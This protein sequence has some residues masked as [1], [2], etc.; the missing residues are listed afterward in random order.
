MTHSPQENRQGQHP[1]RA[2]SNK[3]EDRYGF[4]HIATELARAIQGIGREGSAVIGIEGAWGT[5][6]TSLLNL[7]RTAL[8][9]QQE[10]QTFVLTVS[11]WLDG[12]DTPLVASLL[13]PV[14]A[15][16]AEEE[17][18]RLS[19]GERAELKEK[20][21]LTR[22]ARTLMDYTRATA[23]NLAPVAKI[24]ALIPGAP[25]VSNALNAVAESSWLKEKEKTTADMRTEI[26]QKIE[27][28]DLSFIVLLD[29]LDRLEPAQA[30]EVIRLV[31]SVA[32][33]PRFRYLLCYDKA[34]LSQAISQG[35][36]VA[37]GSLYLQKIIQIAFA[38]PRLESF[39]LRQQF[40][41]AAIELYQTVND[42]PPE[43]GI[44]ADLTAVANIYGATLKTPREVQ[45]VLNALRFR[46]AGMRDYVYFPDLCFL[47]LLRTTNPGLYDWV[48]EYLSEW[49]VVQA[50]DGQV[51][52]EEQKALV[53]SLEHH[54]KRY[55]PA[56][57]H[58]AYMLG[59]WVPGIFG[60]LTEYP[61]KLFAR[62]GPQESAMQTAGKRLSSQVY[63]RY[64]FAFSAP[65]NVLSPQI[66]DQLFT[67]ASQPQK[68][69]EL[70]ECLLGYIQS[71]NL[72]SRTWFEHILTQL[73]SPL[74]EARTSAE[75]RGLLQFFCNN[76]DIMVERYRQDNEWFAL[77]DL[78]TYSVADRLIQ[79]MLRE[80]VASTMKFL[81]AQLQSGKA[82]YWCAEYVRHLLWQHGIV[83]DRTGHQLEE[84]MERS[85]VVILQ[86]TMGKRLKS[87][88]ITDQLPAF[89]LLNWYIWAWRD[90]S[91]APV[92][93]KWVKS[94]VKEDDAFLNLLLLLRYYGTSSAQ[95]YYQA[96]PL[97]DMTEFL[98]DIKTVTNRIES[99]KQAGRFPERVKQV[100][101]S[102]RRSR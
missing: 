73:T 84:W 69:Q 27:E 26:A 20:K 38:L 60:G 63:W 33:F 47:Q 53:G 34:V 64:Y 50:E 2:I 100:E 76:G 5:G 25:D 7:L 81:I 1:D 46:Y 99:I 3:E 48:E 89:A 101:Q 58:S 24:A 97:A 70:A 11:P 82:W 43:K 44:L 39:A 41:D 56:A 91:G 35:L 9:E 23:R 13:L 10:R 95:G 28:L 77:Q 4:T 45:T 75:C 36:G 86:Q 49:N 29:D 74:I 78:D 92:V 16:I 55:F 93:R 66:F 79:R 32:D 52:D 83:G 8:A 18:R 42:F 15:I 87:P 22:T 90:I 30:V 59:Q 62:T 65:Q 57:A 72:S 40:H 61:V 6:K 98:G 96:L 51:S 88:T 37:D 85:N 67:L 71:K 80:D 14:A 21:A 12:S 31:K 19:P 68:Q 94:Q 102:I 54:L 17:E